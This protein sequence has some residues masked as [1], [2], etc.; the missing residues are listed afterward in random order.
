MPC[1]AVSPSRDCARQRSS[2]L[3]VSPRHW[4][5]I[6]RGMGALKGLALPMRPPARLTLWNRASLRVASIHG[7]IAG[8]EDNAFRPRARPVY[9]Q[10]RAQSARIPPSPESLLAT[11][12]PQCALEP[13]SEPHMCAKCEDSAEG[14]IVLDTARGCA[15]YSILR[16]ARKRLSEPRGRPRRREP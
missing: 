3:V 10:G 1:R 6:W 9:M 11:R 14:E 16:Q 7:G 5:S 12:G 15:Y 13:P 2:L 8:M 4:I